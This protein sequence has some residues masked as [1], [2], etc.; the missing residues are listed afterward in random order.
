MFVGPILFLKSFLFIKIYNKKKNIDSSTLLKFSHVEIIL[1]YMFTE[2]NI[3]FLES[4]A[5]VGFSYTNT[6]SNL[7]DSGDKR[8]GIYYII[9]NSY[10]YRHRFNWSCSSHVIISF[11]SMTQ[12]KML[13]F[14]L[15]DGCPDF[16]NTN[17]ENSILLVKVMQVFKQQYIKKLS[18][19]FLRILG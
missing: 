1:L 18:L 17:I 11:P 9:Y 10:I 16:L 5:G 7:K 19:C 3:L 13:W 15:Q 6:S 14:F 2:A 8:T 4:P 12:L